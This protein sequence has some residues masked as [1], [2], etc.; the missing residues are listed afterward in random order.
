MVIRVRDPFAALLGLQ[1][2]MDSVMGSDWFG[3]R[4]SGTGAFPLINVFNDGEDFVLVAEL[5]GVKK[6]DLDVQVRGDTLRI[7]GKK[8]VAY[9]ESASAH[10]RERAAGQFD[11]TLTLPAE[12]DAAKV[13]AEYRDGVL[14]LRLPRAESAKPRTVT[15]N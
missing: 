4:T 7:Q 13:A 3:S 15:I 14:T 5:P 2:A 6:E 8:T 9:D 11:R 12:V 1:R 10:R